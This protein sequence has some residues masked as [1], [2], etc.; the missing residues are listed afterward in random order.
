MVIF[1]LDGTLADS[2]GCVV[3][4][5]QV[6]LEAHGLPA[7]DPEVVRS[8]V[9]LPLRTVVQRSLPEG[10][11]AHAIDAVDLTYRALYPTLASKTER[12]FDGIPELLTSLCDAGATLVIATGKSQRGAE[13]SA[14]RLGLRAHFRS[15]HGIVP[16]TPGK[17]HTAL[18]ERVFRGARYAPDQAVMV[19]DTSYD[20][21]MARH[22]GIAS[23]AVGWGS[24]TLGH[25]KGCGPEALVETVPALGDWLL[26]PAEPTR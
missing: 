6:A 20:L 18:L 10:T 8:L 19:G 2:T 12:L 16:G 5:M 1:D 4:T 7:P 26:S 21:V 14:K 24:H 11:P 23:C 25:L 3:H 15:V 22:F 9:G 17:P 13:A